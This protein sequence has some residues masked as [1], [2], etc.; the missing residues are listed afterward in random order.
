MKTL[1][2]FLFIA[3]AQANEPSKQWPP[4]LFEHCVAY[5]YDFSQDARGSAITFPDGSL[6]KGVI[7]ATT[8]RLSEVQVTKLR[9]LLSTDSKTEH[10]D[11]DC[12]DPHHAF[13]FYDADWKVTASIDVCFLC[14][15]YVARPKGA[16]SLVDIQ[17]LEAFCR[18]VGLPML[19]DSSN[20]TA[21][22]QQEQSTGIP[23]SPPKGKDPEPPVSGELKDDP[24]AP[25]PATTSPKK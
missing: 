8:V 1:I 17:A 13:V 7:K 6:H 12:Y 2:A 22:Y 3:I 10:G 5:C 24:F 18:E 23:Q 4:A 15:D 20:Y 14:D 25:D 11:V 9:A 21:L 19:K 16:S